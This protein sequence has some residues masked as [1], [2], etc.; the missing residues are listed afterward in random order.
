M[1]KGQLACRLSCS[2]QIA[3]ALGAHRLSAQGPNE[4]EGK[5]YIL[6][7]SIIFRLDRKYYLA[8]DYNL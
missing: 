3:F 2:V 4:E 8:K 5:C 6:D 7:L 1:G